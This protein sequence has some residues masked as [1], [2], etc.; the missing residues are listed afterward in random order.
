[1]KMQYT[2]ALA[3][4]ATAIT[5]MPLRAAH[6]DDER[7]ISAAKQSYVYRTFL[8]D[9]RIKI[10]SKD[11]FVI[12]THRLRIRR[13]RP[14]QRTRWKICLESKASIIGWK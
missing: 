14:W 13:T 6:K 3:V 12:L 11:G 2:L 7:I 4:L 8:K 5:A 9:D 10:Q 1:M